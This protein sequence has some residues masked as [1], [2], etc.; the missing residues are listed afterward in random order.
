[1]RV[2]GAQK[3]LLAVYGGINRNTTAGRAR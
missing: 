3:Q 2:A 1:V